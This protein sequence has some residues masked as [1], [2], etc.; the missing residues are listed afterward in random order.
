M[1]FNIRIAHTDD[2][3]DIFRLIQELAL[4]E[5]APD[6]VENTPERIAIDG[7][8]A[9]PAF[10]CF[11]LEIQGRVQGISVC[12]IRY[13]TWKGPV[14]YLEDLIISEA[15]RGK[16]YGKA[17]FEYTLDYARAQGYPRLQWQVLDWN[18]DAM[19]FY[20]AFGAQFDAEWLNAW[21]PLGR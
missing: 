15:F 18:S 7:F 20:D 4:F 3:P 9:N 19:R 1:E 2:V 14:L 6:E 11:V 10:I 5:K 12:Y 8:G 17:L 13:S 16:G 21:I